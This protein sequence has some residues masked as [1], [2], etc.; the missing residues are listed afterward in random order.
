MGLGPYPADFE[1]ADDPDVGYTVTFRDVPGAITQG[2]DLDE[3]MSNGR[4]AIVGGLLFYAENGESFPKASAPKRGERLI[5]V[6]ALSQAKLALI[7]LMAEQDVSN[8]E[9]A[10]RLGCTESIVR[11]LVNINHESKISRVED[12]L[13]ELGKHLS[14]T[15][16]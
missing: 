6:P 3:A 1:P 10:S 16:S 2:D 5:F 15:A 7:K 8:V 14:V 9:L 12:A 4:D 13:V 11:R